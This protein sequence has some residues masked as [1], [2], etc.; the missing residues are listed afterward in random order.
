[1][2]V[3]CGCAHIHTHT[4][5]YTDKGTCTCT[6]AHTYRI[7][8]ARLS[9]A[10][11]VHAVY[12]NVSAVVRRPSGGNFQSCERAAV[13]LSGCVDERVSVA[14]TQ[15]KVVECVGKQ[16]F[17]QL[18]HGGPVLIAEGRLAAVRAHHIL[19]CRAQMVAPSS[20][21]LNDATATVPPIQRKAQHPRGTEAHTG[22]CTERE[23]HTH[24]C[25]CG[26]R[27]TCRKTPLA[28]GGWTA[29]AA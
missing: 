18:D 28:P 3:A 14:R 21:G 23:G 27:G 25:G 26:D 12:E 19:V 16:D 1:L 9:L 5:T 7:P 4:H 22:V 29:T 11:V 15:V 24:Q 13:C 8:H 17:A 20:V 2:Y 6:C 10:A